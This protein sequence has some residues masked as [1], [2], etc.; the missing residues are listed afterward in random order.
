[1]TSPP[2]LFNPDAL[3]RVFDAGLGYDDY[4]ATGTDHQRS[5]WEA[6]RGRATLSD[7][8]S[9]L[10]SGFMRRVNILAVSGIWC[11]DCVQQL[12]FLEAFRRANPDMITLRYLDRD[13]DR[14]FTAPITICSGNRVPFVVFMNED[15]DF[16]SLFGDRS[17]SRYRAMAARQLGPSCPIPGA[18][19]PQDELDAT[20]ADW[21]GELAGSSTK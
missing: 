15:F 3:R 4:L 14:G 10:V 1:M 11:G 20:L 21:L 12:P 7:T 13:A 5:A 8:Q 2:D 6:V 9:A 17:L 19:V 16:L 18:A